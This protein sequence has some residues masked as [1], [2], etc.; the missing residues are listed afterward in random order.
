MTGLSSIPGG[1]RNPQPGDVSCCFTC[2]SVLVLVESFASYRSL[3]A[4]IAT[5]QEQRGFMERNP[6]WAR[7]F[8]LI[9]KKRFG[10]KG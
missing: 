5:E 8:K 6:T 9:A 3:S 1:S 4:R 10:G 7:V 2:G